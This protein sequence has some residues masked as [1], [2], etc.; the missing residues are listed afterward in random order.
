MR[1]AVMLLPLYMLAEL[2]DRKDRHEVSCGYAKSGE[3]QLQRLLRDLDTLMAQDPSAFK[4]IEALKRDLQDVQAR[5]NRVL[6][7]CD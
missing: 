1:N 5:F 2:Y 3:R 4:N 7:E 6:A